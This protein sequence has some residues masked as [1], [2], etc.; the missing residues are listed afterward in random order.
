MRTDH[1]LIEEL[2]D[3][4]LMF[5]TDPVAR[6]LAQHIASGLVD[7]LVDDL[8]RA[9]MD[10]KTCM[11][12]DIYSPGTYIRNLEY[13]VADLQSTLDKANEELER[14]STRTMLSVMQELQREAD[15][16]RVGMQR[17]YASIRALE[18][19]NA[20]LTKKLD[21]WGRLNQVKAQ[22]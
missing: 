3:H 4:V 6:R 7:D 18:E 1:L 10:A 19:S 17:Q 2:V 14:L 11:F 22:A 13:E 12:D 21:M 15:E 16:V 8:A 20:E 5:S 9:G